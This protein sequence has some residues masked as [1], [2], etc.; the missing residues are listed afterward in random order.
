MGGI[1]EGCP[2]GIIIDVL[3]IQR[4]LTRRK[5]GQSDITSQRKETDKV[6]ILSGLF[7]GVTLG[8]PI[9]FIVFNEDH[10]S[11]DYDS[12]KSVFRPGHADEAWTLK[13]G[14]RDYRGGGRSSA[15]ETIS[16]VVGG[17]IARAFL[18]LH[19]IKVIAWVSTIGNHIT[20][21]DPRTVTSEQIENNSVRCPNPEM[22]QKMTEAIHDA[23]QK[24]DSLGGV[25]TCICYGIPPGLGEP[26]FD[27]LP[28]LMAH[29]MMSLPAS[30][31]FESDS[32]LEQIHSLGSQSNLMP[33]GS[34][35]GISNGNPYV[36]R[37]GFK[38]VS[39]ISQIQKMKTE[40]G[41][42]IDLSIKGRHDP[43]VLPRAVPIVEAMAALVLA[44]LLLLNKLSKA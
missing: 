43:C 20:H 14:I 13:Y 12:I 32:G 39:S 30:R 9:G 18:G 22:A 31:S 10:I 2:S 37:I 27:K 26:V 42:V 7:E 34:S 35:G 4:E 23:Q 40:E 25:V 28:S 21:D 17:S 5:P 33:Q 8:T 41:N 38:P 1:V 36:M 44:D 19:G 15:R 3:D 11:A 24:G 29:A 6:E 16:R